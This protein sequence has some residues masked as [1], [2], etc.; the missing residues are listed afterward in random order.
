MRKKM[1]V[2]KFSHLSRLAKEAA[3][4]VLTISGT[5]FVLLLVQ[6]DLIGEGV[7]AMVFLLSVAWAAY[8]WG[9]AAGMSAALTAALMFDFLFIPPFYTF[10]IDRPEGILSL[11]IFL[12]VAIVIVERI[13]ATLSKAHQSE[14]EAVLMYEFTTILAGLRSLDAIARRVT[15]FARQRFML[16]S[17]A[18][19]IHPKGGKE[20]FSDQSPQ[21][22]I[23]TAK[24]DCILPLID[25][26]GLVGEMQLWRG[27]EMEL[28]SPESR[29]FRNIALQI[30]LAIERVQITEYEVERAVR[31]S[32]SQ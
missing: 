20:V 29:L 3:S 8:R 30:G 16:E 2:F 15:Q 14:Q 24:P 31:E 26:W 25:S 27:A 32:V 22:K 6:R 7:I 28:P 21:D 19:I 17:A 10:T 9:L 4:A 5:A 12:F 13:Q 18:V 1:K 23:M 11:V